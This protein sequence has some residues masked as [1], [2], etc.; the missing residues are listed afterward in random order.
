MGRASQSGG[1][2]VLAAKYR[3]L[4]LFVRVMENLPGRMSELLNLPRLRRSGFP[5]CV[6]STR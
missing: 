1:T 6:R 5:R 3:Y 2:G 4:F